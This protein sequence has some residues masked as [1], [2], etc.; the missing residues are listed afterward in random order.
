MKA[1][2]QF[3]H[4]TWITAAP[5]FNIAHL[6]QLSRLNVQIFKLSISLHP[7]MYY[8]LAL[9][10]FPA[11][12][13]HYCFCCSEL[14]HKPEIILDC[15]MPSR[16]QQSRHKN[17]NDSMKPSEQRFKQGFTDFPV[18]WVLLCCKR[19]VP[20]KLVL[21]LDNSSPPCTENV[22]FYVHM[23]MMWKQFVCTRLCNKHS[24]KH[25]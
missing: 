19:A 15:E 7:Q 6:D 13:S 2:I 5:S 22:F 11:N 1:G 4:E 10:R 18:L 3:G 9:M 14:R 24:W 25:S 20:P 23:V 17:P 16:V 8:C 21:C 12:S